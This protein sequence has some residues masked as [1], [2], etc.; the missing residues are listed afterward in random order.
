MLDFERRARTGLAEA[1]FCIRKSSKQVADILG[2]FHER[3]QSCL[4]TR[5]TPEKHRQLPDAWRERLDFDSLS[6]TAFFG[7]ISAPSLPYEVAIVS[8]GTSDASVCAEAARTLSYYGVNS[9]LYQ[10]VGVAG[11]WRLLERI[12]EIRAFP[13]VIAV[14]GMEGAIFSVLGGLIDAVLIALP[15]SVSYGIGPDGEL[16]LHAALGSCAP[17]I[18]TVNID[19]GYGAACAAI[20]IMNQWDSKPIN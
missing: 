8:G 7:R 13:V 20:R 1:V 4:L 18:L 11:L 3:G 2:R 16:A 12:D 6:G 19:N 9:R 5:L 10:D 17:G 14:A 15:T